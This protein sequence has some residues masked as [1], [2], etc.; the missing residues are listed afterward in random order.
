MGVNSVFLG[1]KQVQEKLNSWVLSSHKTNTK[2]L[3]M[4]I[5]LTSDAIFFPFQSTK[6]SMWR[7]VSLQRIN[8]ELLRAGLDLGSVI[9]SFHCCPP[10]PCCAQEHARLA[11]AAEGREI[12]SA[13]VMVNFICQ[14]DWPWGT[15][16]S[17]HSISLVCL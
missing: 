6:R 4:D 9:H 11:L 2:L 12:Q 15:W 16:I 7:R 5:H 14:L 1:T 3:H 13:S 10:S 17:A 8:A